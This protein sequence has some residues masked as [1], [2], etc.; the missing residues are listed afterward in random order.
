MDTTSQK[1]VKTSK[2]KSN[3]EILFQI[4]LPLGLFVIIFLFLCVLVA[5]E[6]T[7]GT[8]SVHHWANISFL[9]I[10]IPIMIFSLIFI[11]ILAALIYGQA[12][13]IRW[14]PL[15]LKKIYLFVLKISLWIWNFTQKLTSPAIKVKSEIYGIKHGL[16]P[17][18][19]KRD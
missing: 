11:I 14:L 16:H 8:S 9:F 15:Q 1:A 10:S 19:L 2:K 12:K 17:K 4:Y 18:Q 7:G 13:L 6:S 3:Q 5:F